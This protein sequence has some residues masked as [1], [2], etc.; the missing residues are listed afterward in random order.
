MATEITTYA[1]F[2]ARWKLALFNRSIESFFVSA[3]EN[4]NEMRRTYTLLGNVERFTAWLESK[5]A[6]EA[7]GESPGA[8]YFSVGG[9]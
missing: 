1:E 2:L 5:A 4:R 7:Q 3:T 8:M 6:E 9:E